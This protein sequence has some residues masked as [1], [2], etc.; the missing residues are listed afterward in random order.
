MNRF[1]HSPFNI[2]EYIDHESHPEEEDRIRQKM[3]ED[4]GIMREI[5]EKRVLNSHL[6]VLFSKDN[7]A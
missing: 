1:Y 3:Y 2:D 5:S 4:P 7:E 6:Q